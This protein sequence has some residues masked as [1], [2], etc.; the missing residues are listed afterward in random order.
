M[1]RTDNGRDRTLAA[2][3]CILTA[4]AVIGF[5]DQY[6]GRLAETSSVWSFVLVRTAIIFALALGFAILARRPLRVRRWRGVLARAAVMGAALVIYFGALG[7]LSVAEAAAGLFTAPIWVLLLSVAWGLR[8]GPVRMV[9]VAL[10]FAGVLLVLAPDP[11]TTSAWLILP[12]L[13]GALYGLGAL[14][15]RE[16]CEGEGALELSLANFGAQAVWSALAVAV[17][18]VVGAGDTFVTRGWVWPDGPTLAICAMQAAGSLVAVTLLTKGYQLTQ[19]S[20]A[21]V[22]EYS[23]LGFSALF[24]W[25]V[26]GQATGPWGLLGLGLIALAGSLIA[27]RARA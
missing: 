24:G 19:A 27:L 11:A 13:A 17:I 25:I 18:A 10:G 20:L 9:A 5:I 6:V 2:A 7:F 4:M 12:V 23:V 26:A 16:W 1:E 21:S 3:G 14:A 15:T 22:F 8:V